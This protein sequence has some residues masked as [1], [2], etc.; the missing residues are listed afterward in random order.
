M[1]VNSPSPPNAQQTEICNH[2]DIKYV[3]RIARAVNMKATEILKYVKNIAM[4]T[5]D[6]KGLKNVLR[7]KKNR[8]NNRS[9]MVDMIGCNLEFEGFALELSQED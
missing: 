1:A 7:E 4:S 9:L 3:F 6:E 5:R 8:N 2:V